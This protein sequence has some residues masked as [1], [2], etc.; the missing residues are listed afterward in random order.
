MDEDGDLLRQTLLQGTLVGSGSLLSLEACD[1]LLRQR[2][3]DLDIACR[4]GIIDIQPEL[5]EGV[6]ARALGIE[7][8]IATL[9]LTELTTV[10]LRD[11]RTYQSIASPASIRRISSV[12]VV[13]FPHWSEPPICRRQ[14]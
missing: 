9:G 1:L 10:G 12:P 3:E 7:P 8:Y 6:W 14:P 5:V 2:R 4:I 11:Q 13:I